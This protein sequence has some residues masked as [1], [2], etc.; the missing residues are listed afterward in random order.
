MDVAVIHYL[1]NEPFRVVTALEEA[2]PERILRLT[3]KGCLSDLKTTRMGDA[4]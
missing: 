3:Q 1:V 4:R 2:L